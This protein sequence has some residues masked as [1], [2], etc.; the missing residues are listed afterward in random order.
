MLLIYE[1]LTT[2]TVEIGTCVL[3]FLTGYVKFAYCVFERVAEK[4]AGI[5]DVVVKESRS[6]MVSGQ[7]G[8]DW[9]VGRTG[10]PTLRHLLIRGGIS[11]ERE[12]CYFFLKRS[13][14]HNERVEIVW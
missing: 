6:R 10:L 4:E 13:M 5:L 1:L 14:S 12:S 7:I 8:G 2:N 11:R 9:L 3:F